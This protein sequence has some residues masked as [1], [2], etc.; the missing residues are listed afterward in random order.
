MLLIFFIFSFLIQ[1][2]VYLVTPDYS[3]K[4]LSSKTMFEVNRHILSQEFSQL[5]S[6]WLYKTGFIRY[7][8]TVYKY[9]SYETAYLII[10][11]H[12]LKYST[13]VNFNDPFD[14]TMNLMDT[15]IE[16][17]S[18]VK[19][20]KIHWTDDEFLQKT[21]I[22][23]FKE[24]PELFGQIF[25]EAFENSR[26]EI[27]ISCFSKSPLKTLMWSHYADSHRGVCLGFAFNELPQST[28]QFP[29]NYVSELM[30]MNLFDNPFR[31][32][33]NWLFTKSHVWEYEEEVRIAY[34]F[35]N[36]LI[37][38][39]ITSLV[40]VYYGL[41]LLPE[42]FANIKNALQANG[43]KPV[44]EKQMVMNLATFDL[45]AVTIVPQ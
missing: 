44:I 14:L 17:E 38:F 5:D 13:S 33:I 8:G 7:P 34:M 45:K 26:N 32:L 36:G 41:R 24:R 9:V 30:S 19:D 35:N 21:L 10:T 16:M 12:C 22:K 15:S 43:F 4:F 39:P 1:L 27:G 25:L 42:N 2:N 23:M 20:I 11:G 31:A 37:P 3:Y 29:V 18:I 6:D 40:E 28:M